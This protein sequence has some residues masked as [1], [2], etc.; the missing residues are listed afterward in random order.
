MYFYYNIEIIVH[1]NE[2]FTASKIKNAGKDI[3]INVMMI[4]FIFKNI[5]FI[6]LI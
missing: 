3:D 2:D 5:N 4:I 6:K 1:S